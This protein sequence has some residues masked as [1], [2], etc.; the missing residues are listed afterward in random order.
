MAEAT[1]NFPEMLTALSLV[2]LPFKP[3]EHK[4][5]FKGTQMTLTAGSPMIVYHEEIQPAAKV[6]EHT[7]ILVSENFFRNGDRY[8]QV[9]GEQVDKFV[10]ENS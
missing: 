1:H 7:P 9:N 10:T 5:E 8:R 4:T 6:A 2:D 3:A